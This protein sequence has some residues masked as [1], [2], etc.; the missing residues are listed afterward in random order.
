MKY[1]FVYP[2][3]D[4]IGSGNILTEVNV[5]ECLSLKGVL[6][7]IHDIYGKTLVLT[8]LVPPTTHVVVE[9]KSDEWPTE[10]RLIV[11]EAIDHL[12]G[13]ENKSEP[14]YVYLPNGFVYGLCNE[15][16]TDEDKR[17]CFVA[18]HASDFVE[19]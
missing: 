3:G 10:D 4:I 17:L 1:K 14:L 16:A 19:E 18:A 8:N 11:Q 12:M 13:M 9:D 6:Y 7:S 15:L 5:G 2:N